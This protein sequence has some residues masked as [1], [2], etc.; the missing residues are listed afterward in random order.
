MAKGEGGE[1]MEVGMSTG[2]ER[3][4]TCVSEWVTHT[5]THTHI[6]IHTH[7]AK[8]AQTCMAGSCIP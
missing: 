1:E 3:V 4:C 8:L 5:N 6:H 2:K 7:T